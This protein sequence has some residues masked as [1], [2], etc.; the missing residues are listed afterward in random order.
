MTPSV[1]AARLQERD[2]GGALLGRGMPAIGLHV[3]AGHDLI[4][5]GD[6]AI[7]RGLVPDEVRV[8]HGV[9]IG[10][11]GERAGLAAYDPVEIGPEAIVA[12]AHCV[13]GAAGIVEQKLPGVRIGP[14]L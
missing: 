1:G 13:T 11:A 14:V 8:L 10:V 5:I 3:V 4:G 7:E 9:G 6:E 12:V 2:D